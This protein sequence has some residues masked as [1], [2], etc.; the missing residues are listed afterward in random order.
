MRLNSSPI[1][2]YNWLDTKQTNFEN[3]HPFIHIIGF[4][5]TLLNLLKVHV[6]T[7]VRLCLH[8]IDIMTF[9]KGELFKFHSV[10]Y[11]EC[12]NVNYVNLYKEICSMYNYCVSLMSIILIVLISIFYNNTDCFNL[13]ILFWFKFHAFI[14][15]LITSWF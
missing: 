9:N 7:G 15:F 1:Q 2:L 10:F 4:L 8:H 6:L 11:I 13:Y 12:L 3:I 5:I 14:L